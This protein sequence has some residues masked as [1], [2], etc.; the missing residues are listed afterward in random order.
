MATINDVPNPNKRNTISLEI[1]KDWT[2]RWRAMESDYNAHNDCR[3]FNIPL[4]DLQE[5]IKE[6][7]VASVRG[8]IGVEK[9]II[10]GEDV[11][12]E[13]LIIVGVDANGKD[14]ITSSDGVTLDIGGGDLY[15]F[16]NPCPNMCDD[17][18]PL[19]G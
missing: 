8:Y 7:G 11:F 17:I 9:Q 6:E 5:V 16:T 4:I 10:E 19:N 18:S 13:K 3:A 1:A 12:I 14:M 2:T 15:D